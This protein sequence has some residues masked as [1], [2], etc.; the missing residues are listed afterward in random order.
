MRVAPLESAPAQGGGGAGNSSAGKPEK[1]NPSDFSVTAIGGDVKET[2]SSLR[3]EVLRAADGTTI[4]ER[5]TDA[6]LSCFDKVYNIGVSS[7][8]SAS[9][10]RL[11]LR[12][13]TFRRDYQVTHAC[14][15]LGRSRT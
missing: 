7:S 11:R 5:D 12:L 3:E 9:V 13:R 15:S 2:F 14:P 8:V 4:Q 6:A 1:G 10:S